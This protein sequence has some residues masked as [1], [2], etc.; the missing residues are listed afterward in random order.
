MKT[1]AVFSIA[2]LGLMPIAAK[3]VNKPKKEYVAHFEIEFEVPAEQ[4]LAALQE[5]TTALFGRHCVDC[6][7]GMYS[8]RED[9]LK[10]CSA[11]GNADP[12]QR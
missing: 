4:P 7:A 11:C 2:A 8:M 5:E 9:G 3:F 6:S 10:R 12:E 1:L